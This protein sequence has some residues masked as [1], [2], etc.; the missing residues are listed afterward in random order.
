A[1]P[2]ARA[3]AVRHLI[4]LMQ[5]QYVFSYAGLTQGAD[6]IRTKDFMYFTQ[7]CQAMIL[8][9]RE[10]LPVGLPL[11]SDYERRIRATLASLANTPAT[12]TPVR[13]AARCLLP[14]R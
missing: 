4:V 1:T 5:P 10:G 9:A 8:A 2:Q 13:N 3:F 6:T 12:P 11:P 14:P 7:G